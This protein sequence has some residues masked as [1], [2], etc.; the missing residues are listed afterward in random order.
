MYRAGTASSVTFE[1]VDSNNEPRKRLAG[2]TRFRQIS[3]MCAHFWI[4]S[5]I[6][7]R[8]GTQPVRP[9]GALFHLVPSLIVCQFPS[10]ADFQL[11][12]ENYARQLN[13][14]IMVLR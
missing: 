7:R 14:A 9:L 1:A 10:G 12:A 8:R 6:R 2:C 13:D 4:G 11:A 3:A 5:F